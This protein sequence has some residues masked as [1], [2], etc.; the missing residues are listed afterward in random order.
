MQKGEFDLIRA[1]TSGRQSAA[2]QQAC[3]VVQGIGDDAAVTE[4][5]AGTQMVATCDTMVEDVH[6]KSITMRDRDVGY[7]AMASAVSDIAAMGAIPKYALVS[8]S[9]PHQTEEKRLLDIYDGLYECASRWSV[10]IIGGDTTSSPAG[11]HCSV[12]VIGEVEAGKALLRSSAKVGDVVFVTGMLGRSAAGLDFLLAQNKISS[13]WDAFP[14]RVQ[15]L[16]EAHCRPS[17]QIEAGLLLQKLGVCH[18][19]NDVS[20]GLA[21]EAW[22]I[23]EASGV[24]I[25]LVEDRIPV[26]EELQSFAENRRK[27][28]L[29]Y[30][31]YGGEDYELVGTMPAD[32]AIEAQLKFREAGLELH[33]IGYVN[34]EHRRVMLVQSS[35]A[36]TAVPKRGYNHFGE[37]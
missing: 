32:K 6:F 26:A 28:P 8:V 25:D 5:A 14:D 23:V 31:L 34:G 20:D 3:G 19:L 11:I 16:I 9:L 17:P 36:M 10:V 18:A 7:K 35:G 4:W 24:G 2:F 21:S 33:V 27:D 13:E 15:K 37:E 29:D 22:E 12:T 1:W 30:I